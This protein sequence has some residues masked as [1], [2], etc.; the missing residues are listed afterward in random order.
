MS[1]NQRVTYQNPLRCSYQGLRLHYTENF[2]AGM[3]RFSTRFWPG[4]PDGA[5]MARGQGLGKLENQQ[6]RPATWLFWGCVIWTI[7]GPCNFEIFWGYWRD[8]KSTD[9]SHQLTVVEVL[10]PSGLGPI[11]MHYGPKQWLCSCWFSMVQQPT[12]RHR[13]SRVNMTEVPWC[14]VLQPAGRASVFKDLQRSSQIFKDL[15]RSSKCVSVFWKIH[16]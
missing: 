12:V 3:D 7:I 2:R 4:S 15:Q 16:S 6:K 1:N 9:P 11:Q 10:D 13:S 5:R 14:W 8:S